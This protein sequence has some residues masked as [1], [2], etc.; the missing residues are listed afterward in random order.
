MHGRDRACARR[1]R[2]RSFSGPASRISGAER[3]VE[4]VP[5]IQSLRHHR[6]LLELEEYRHLAYSDASWTLAPTEATYRF[7]TELYADLLPCFSSNYVNVCC[8][9]AYD[10]TGPTPDTHML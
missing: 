10:L 6:R 3:A 5:R 2:C 4:L 1:A 7:L 8:D 9:E